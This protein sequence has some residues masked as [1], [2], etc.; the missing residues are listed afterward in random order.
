[1]DHF[2]RNAVAH[3]I[4]GGFRIR[5]RKLSFGGLMGNFGRLIFLLS[6]AAYEKNWCFIFRPGTLTFELEVYK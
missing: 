5:N 4:G 6:P 1:M 2:Q 3:Y